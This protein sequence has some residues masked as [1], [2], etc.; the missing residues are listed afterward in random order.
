MGIV[1]TQG[2]LRAIHIAPQVRE[3]AARR[4]GDPA[5]TLGLDF[6]DVMAANATV[7]GPDTGYFDALGAIPKS[8]R[9]P[10]EPVGRNLFFQLEYADETAAVC[11]RNVLHRVPGARRASGHR[12]GDGARVRVHAV[13][14][15]HGQR[16]RQGPPRSPDRHAPLHL[17]RAA[18]AV[19]VGG[20]LRRDHGH[21]PVARHRARQHAR[22]DGP[23]VHGG[24][25]RVRRAAS[26]GRRRRRVQELRQG[27]GP[28]PRPA[29]DLHGAL[30][31]R[32]GRPERPSAP[33]A[34]R[35][36]GARRC[37]TTPT[38]RAACR[39]RCTTCSAAY[40]G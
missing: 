6:H 15:D 3:G 11:T 8:C 36:R 33:V 10:W 40:S 13:Q 9:I 29:A 28:P 31:E 25:D 34:A 32:G 23:R 16:R 12:A 18:A 37:C 4:Q 19:R 5:V 14:R 27:R 39:R 38:G 20:V 17:L 26:R 30:V 2:M 7:G 35:S 24:H 22:G 1:D 21:L